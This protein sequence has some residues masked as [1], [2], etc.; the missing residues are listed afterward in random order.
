MTECSLSRFAALKEAVP[1]K[2]LY[3]L[4]ASTFA[5]KLKRWVFILVADMNARRSVRKVSIFMTPFYVFIH[6]NQP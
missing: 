5:S 6:K 3:R 2:K 1:F 4:L